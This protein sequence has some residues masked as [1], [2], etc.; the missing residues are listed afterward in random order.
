MLGSTALQSLN[1]SV[2]AIWVGRLLGD[3]ALT[4]TGNG[5]IVMFLLLAAVIGL[6]LAATIL[7]GQ[8]MGRKDVAEARRVVGTA[9]TFF[10]VLSVAVGLAGYLLTG[11]ML[12]ALETPPEAFDQAVLYM[13]AVFL[14]MPFAY[15]NVFAGMALR[16]AGDSRS[17]FRFM[18][19][20]VAVD[21]A[22]NPVLIL[23]L[24]P[25]PAL[26][27]TGSGVAFLISQAV[28]L[29]GLL[30]YLAHRRFPLLL[31]GPDTALFRPDH[32][33][34]RAVVLKGVPMGL[35]M[36]V[37]AFSGLAMIALANRHGVTTVA[38][39]AVAMQLWA[40]VQMPCFALGAASSSMAAQNVGAGRWDRVN[41]I[42]FKGTLI[43]TGL[44]ALAIAIVYLFEGQLA[45]LFL[46]GDAAAQAVTAR[47]NLWGIW[48]WL[49]FG[50]VMVLF[51]VVRATGAVIA[52]LLILG[53]T[54]VVVRVPLAVVLE[55]RMGADAIWF[56]SPIS[57][58]LTLVLAFLYFRFGGW[59]EAKMLEDGR[60]SGARHGGEVPVQ[61]AT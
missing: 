5:N 22:L 18:A 27:I 43:A 17:P 33:I 42:A 16:G 39:Y 41:A 2:N 30:A 12:R 50:G 53:F 36:V 40:Y 14:A 38:G 25:F 49:F 26:G 19:L 31:R 60:A 8:A 35:Q 45:A 15:L 54:L 56:T 4:A 7:I 20:G 3:T 34:L 10:L 29:V 23:G 59:R 57:L 21:I 28:A 58:G 32:R 13:R 9:S 47:V 6:G 24:G 61:P 11:P 37:V 52:P 48:G 55:G 44:T 46:P 51:A 1:G